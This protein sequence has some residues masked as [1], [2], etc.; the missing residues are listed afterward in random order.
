MNVVPKAPVLA[1]RVIVHHTLVFVE[2]CRTLWDINTVNN[3]T[4]FV[5]TKE[6]L[7]EL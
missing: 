2:M 6:S 5:S 4:A 7:T 3:E 1:I